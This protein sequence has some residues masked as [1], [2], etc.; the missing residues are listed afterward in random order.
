MLVVSSIEQAKE[1]LLVDSR[2]FDQTKE[3]NIYEQQQLLEKKHTRP[4]EKKMTT[5]TRLDL[6][7]ISRDD[8]ERRR[9]DKN[10]FDVFK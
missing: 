9:E 7:R 6:E 2:I 5:A 4:V 1:M 3:K 8:C 10:V